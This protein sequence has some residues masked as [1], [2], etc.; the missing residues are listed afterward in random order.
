MY[1]YYTQ[2]SLLQY[3]KPCKLNANNKIKAL[4]YNSY[5]TVLHQQINV[6]ENKTNHTK[7]TRGFISKETVVLRR[8]GHE[9]QNVRFIN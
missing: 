9:T 5:V 3:L 7:L 4:L 1:K 8:W 2:V 6:A